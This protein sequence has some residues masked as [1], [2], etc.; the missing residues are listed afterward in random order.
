MTDLAYF[1]TRQSYLEATARERIDGILDSGTFVEILPPEDRIRSPHLGLLNHPAAFDDGLICGD[2]LCGDRAV[3]IAAQ[4]GAFIGGAVGEVH[5]A[6]LTGILERA[7]D[8]RVDAAILLFDSGGVRLHEANAGLIAI[9][10]IQRAILDA[11]TA[12]VTVIAVVGSGNGCFGGCGIV[13][14]SCDRLIMSEEGRISVAGPEVIET[15]HGVEEFDSQDRAMVWRTMGG[16][17]RYAM[18]DADT[19]VPDDMTAFKEAVQSHL[20]SSQSL[21]LDSVSAEH[22][23]LGQRLETFGEARDSFEIWQKAGIHTPEGVPGMEID[24][25][26]A[27]VAATGSRRT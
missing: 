23:R 11:R 21:D 18:G 10:E 20:S 13:A 14:K 15:A 22:T 24:A 26:V 27:L 5:G 1:L 9:S 17:H 7:A 8:L 12:G 3:V 2:G 16:K 19:L 6:K 4:E 25:F